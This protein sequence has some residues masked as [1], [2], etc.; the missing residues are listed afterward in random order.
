MPWWLCG[1]FSGFKMRYQEDPGTHCIS[2]EQVRS[3]LAKYQNHEL[4]ICPHCTYI[5]PAG[6]M[7]YAAAEGLAAGLVVLA[8]VAGVAAIVFQVNSYPMWFFWLVVF[9]LLAYITVG[10]TK[11]YECPCCV[12][13]IQRP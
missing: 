3:N 7:R 13:E 5:G 2:Q 8:L 10:P 11:V 4:V 1:I 9:P 12:G 6:F